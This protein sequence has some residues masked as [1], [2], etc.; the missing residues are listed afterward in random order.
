MVQ[1]DFCRSDGHA[2]CTDLLCLDATSV[3]PPRAALFLL[4]TSAQ[5]LRP[6][7]ENRPPDG[8]KVQTIIARE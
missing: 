6:K 8:F 1:S 3:I 7:P 5:V 2:S 4:G